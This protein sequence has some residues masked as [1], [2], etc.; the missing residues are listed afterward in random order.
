MDLPLNEI[1]LLVL[2]FDGVFTDNRVYLNEEGVESVVCHRGDGMGISLLKKQTQ[3]P[4]VVISTERNKV[5]MARCQKLNIPCFHGIDD[6]LTQLKK[7]VDHYQT[8]LNNVMFVGNDV[9]DLE[10]L[11][12]SGVGTIVADAHASVVPHANLVLKNKGGDGAVREVCDLLME[13][14]RNT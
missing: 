14:Q 12:A 3:M 9:N 4:V 8:T 11:Q 5:V 10:C 1:K 7:V 6:K 13:H 2:D